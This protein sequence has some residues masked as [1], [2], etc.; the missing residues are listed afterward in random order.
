MYLVV[1]FVLCKK[2]AF[3]TALIAIYLGMLIAFVYAKS[4][5]GTAQLYEHNGMHKLLC[6][7]KNFHFKPVFK[8]WQN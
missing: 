5:F 8:G 3:K 4:I 6:A 2:T 1:S 7:V